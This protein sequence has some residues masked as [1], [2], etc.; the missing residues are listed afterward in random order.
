MRAGSE[1]AVSVSILC[2]VRNC[3]SDV[4]SSRSIEKRIMVR[5]TAGAEADR[6]QRFM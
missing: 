2:G 1:A 5:L 3:A 6:P 4:H